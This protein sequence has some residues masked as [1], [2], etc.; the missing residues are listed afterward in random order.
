MARAFYTVRTS[1]VRARRVARSSRRTGRTSGM[2]GRACTSRPARSSRPGRAAAR[3]CPPSTRSPCTPLPRCS[4]AWWTR[5]VSVARRGRGSTRTTDA[6][7]AGPALTLPGLRGHV[8][9]AQDRVRP[10]RASS[11]SADPA[12]CRSAMERRRGCAGAKFWVFCPRRLGAVTVITTPPTAAATKSSSHHSPSRRSRT[13]IGVVPPGL[14]TR[15]ICAVREGTRSPVRGR[16]DNAH[17][18]SCIG[19]RNYPSMLPHRG[20]PRTPTDSSSEILY[21]SHWR[22]DC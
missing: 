8:L 6:S 21:R 2:G 11:S 9:R 17:L 16:R 22:C 7:P 19:R 12:P 13:R 1:A 3:T 4:S 10:E 14:L 20:I 18:G 5:A 15:A